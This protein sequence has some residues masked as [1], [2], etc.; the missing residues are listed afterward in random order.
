MGQLYDCDYLGKNIPAE[1]KCFQTVSRM[2]RIATLKH[3]PKK[4]LI[5]FQTVSRMMRIATIL[6][7]ASGL[8]LILPDRIQDDEDCDMIK[9]NETSPVTCFQ[10]VSRMMRIATS[11]KNHLYNPAFLP[12]RIQ[13]DEDCDLSSTFA[14]SA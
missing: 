5:F 9:E 1:P 12:D 13:D 10:T 11:K 8:I 6:V 7:I 14:P 2:M 3:N 4:V